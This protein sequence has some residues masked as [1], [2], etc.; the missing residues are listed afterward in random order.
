MGLDATGGQPAGEAELPK[1]H[2]LRAVLDG[3][4]DAVFVK[5]RTGR[6]LVINAAGA[7]YLG[8]TVAEVV[9]R[10]DDE[11]WPPATARQIM[12]HDRQVMETG[13]PQSFEA[14]LP[15]ADSARIFLSTKAPYRDP[16]GR[17]VGLIG[18]S[19]DI[20]E[21]KRIEQALRESE[22][23]VAR[24]L[25]SAMDAIVA[26]DGQRTIQLFNAA[27]EDVFR[28][29]AAE[30]VGQPF[31]RFAS[32]ALRD[33]LTRCQRAF[34][35]NQVKK[36]YV[37]VPGGLVARRA[38]GE[39]FP[40]EATISRVEQAHQPLLTLILRDVNERRRAEEELR[41]LQLE[42]LYLHE[43]VRT[44]HGPDEMVGESPAIRRV[45]D[46]IEQVAATD[47]TVLITGET[48][49]GKELVARAIHARSARRPAMLVKVNCAALPGGLVE[50]E[51]F[52]HEK[53]AFTGAIARKIGRF[54]LAHGGTIFL[55]EIGDLP[56]E[57]QAKLLRVLQE[58][59]F[60]R[61]GGAEMRR[62]D[63]RV[64]AATNQHIEN[65]VAEGRFREDLYYRLHVFPIHVPPLR[66]RPEDIPLLARH[67]ALTCGKKMGK[68]IESIPPDMMH[69]LRGHAWP[70]NVRELHNVIERAV[71]LSRGGVLELGEWPA[72]P[73]RAAGSSEGNGTTPPSLRDVERQHII[74]ML[75]RTGWRV[76]GA[77]GA[78]AILGLKPTTLESR[79][80]NLG[81][82]RPA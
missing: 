43:E 33:M 73:V 74:K 23:R 42:N 56:L 12:A 45:F 47:A 14:A 50:S 54:E 77:K 20:T 18:I 25:E 46:A 52:G 29:S 27:A 64:I 4:T 8:H 61:V 72:A 58:G 1:E 19:R 37:W 51:L 2:L 39:E 24:I 75:E 53:G 17:V 49:T 59:E 44:S 10:R 71:I 35:Q 13:E 66:E 36:R 15:V 6:Y 63:V 48:G 34:A 78:A 69:A 40:I 7:G 21:R 41:K 76:S 60:E 80:K 65:A 81:I 62:V 28:C 79:M 16:E 38:D 5:D 68:R 82:H 26:I 31:D 67:F 32:P 11:L 30:A 9:G 70:G 3:T 57:L 22:E 55:D